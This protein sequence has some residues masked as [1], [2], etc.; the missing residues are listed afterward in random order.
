VL[1]D[2]LT[3]SSFQSVFIRMPG[4]WSVIVPFPKKNH[5]NGNKENYVIAA[6][7]PNDALLTVKQTLIKERYES[8][9]CDAERDI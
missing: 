5:D 6:T 2:E 4:N 7:D 1:L 3:Y 8:E 9:R